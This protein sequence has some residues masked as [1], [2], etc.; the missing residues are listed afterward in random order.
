[1]TSTASLNRNNSPSAAPRIRTK[2]LQEEAMLRIA[3]LRAQIFRARELMAWSQRIKEDGIRERIFIC[4][5]QGRLTRLLRPLLL[6]LR[7]R[8]SIRENQEM[9]SELSCQL[10]EMFEAR[11]RANLQ[12]Y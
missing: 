12:F 5:T 8:I 4:E 7:T 3:E 10:F 11:A 2:E 6:P 9:L 1:M